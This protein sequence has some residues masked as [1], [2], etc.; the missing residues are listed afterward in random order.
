V[1]RR[2]RWLLRRR[3]GTED[4][5][6]HSFGIRL[7]ATATITFAVIGITGYVLLER[8][9][10]QRQITDYASAQRAD[11]KAFE[12]EGT[13]AVSTDDGITDIDRFLAGVAQRPGT[14]EGIPDQ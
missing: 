4:G 11:G 2:R 6:A 10:S 12:R 9:L 5:S 7:F 13:R 3:Y 1:V 14:L 8:N